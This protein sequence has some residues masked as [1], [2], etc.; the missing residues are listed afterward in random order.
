MENSKKQ[1]F[2][3][4]IKMILMVVMVI[5]L[6]VVEMWIRKC[7]E[8]TQVL[9]LCETICFV[10]KLLPFIGKSG[11]T[12]YCMGYFN[13]VVKFESQGKNETISIK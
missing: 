6:V 3:I 5:I 7:Y 10:L 2:N 11:R 9:Y 13:I 4:Y 12:K 8:M 1:S